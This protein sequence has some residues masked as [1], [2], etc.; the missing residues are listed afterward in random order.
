MLPDGKLSSRNTVNCIDATIKNSCDTASSG[1]CYDRP[2]S[3][4]HNDSPAHCIST[5]WQ[6]EEIAADTTAGGKGKGIPPWWRY[7]SG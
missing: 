2:N 3:G 4:G 7:S 5:L 1:W 6:E